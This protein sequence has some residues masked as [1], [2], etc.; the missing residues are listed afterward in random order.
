MKRIRETNRCR[1]SIELFSGAGGLALATHSAGFSHEGLFEWNSD[2]CRTL[3]DNSISNSLQGI[4]AW[5]GKI[6]E[7][8]VTNC[9]FSKYENIDLVAGGPPCQPFSLGGKHGG[10]TDHRDMIPQFIRAI[11]ESR[12]K[13]FLMENVRGLARKSFA[14]YLNYSILQLSFPE[15]EIR[16]NEDWTGHLRRLQK[17]FTSRASNSGLNYHVVPQ[18]LNAADY[19]VPQCRERLFIVGFRSDINANWCFPQP[20]H[21]VDRLIFEQGVSFEYWRRLGI[22]RRDLAPQ[23]FRRLKSVKENREST[24]LPWKTVREA[25]ADLPEPFLNDDN[26]GWILNHRYQDGARPYPGHTGSPIDA[27]SKT[28]KAG[29]HGVPGGE[30]M[31]DFG[32]GT[33]RYLSI[34]EAAR[35]QTFPDKWRFHGAWSEAMRQLGNAVPVQ[36]A[37]IVASSIYSTLDMKAA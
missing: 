26:R 8:D 30:N 11:R 19:G 24:L 32:D 13:A 5:G 31:I 20:T 1:S 7:G 33:Y 27:P 3:I 23:Y 21:S 12:P 4:T 22:K 2:A 34:R 36:L 18:I 6:Y 15:I 16:S 29:G 35:I 17:H 9:S 14:T 25:I 37:E 10:M 28:L